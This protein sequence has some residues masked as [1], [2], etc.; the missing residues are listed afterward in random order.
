MA[1][2]LQLDEFLNDVKLKKVNSIAVDEDRVLTWD[3]VQRLVRDTPSP[4]VRLIIAFLAMTGARISE[5]LNIELGD[6]K[7]NGTYKIRLRGKGNKERTVHATADLVDKVKARFKGKRWLF[8]HSGRQYNR[9]SITQMIKTASLKVLGREISAHVLRHS[10]ATK[11]LEDGNSLKAV[12]TYLGHSTTA[13]TADIYQHDTMKANAAI[14]D[15]DGE[16]R[17]T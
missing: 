2:Q 8:E 17:N 12:S 3:E 9:I 1:K 7:K 10:W 14:L 6:M 11:Q 16:P 4:K 13:I 15:V 5:A